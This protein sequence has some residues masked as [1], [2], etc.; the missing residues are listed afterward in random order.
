MVMMKLLNRIA[1]A[2][3]EVLMRFVAL[4]AFLLMSCGVYI[5]ND[6]YYT[7][8][9]A[10]ISYD[11]LQY[12]PSVDSAGEEQYGFTE[13]KQIN[14]DT[15]GWIELFDTHI[16]YPVVQ[17]H[18]N[19]EYLNKDIFGYNT[20]SGS[21]YLAAENSSGFDDW[22]N[23]VYGHH[24]DNGAM[25]GDIAKYLDPDF[26]TSHSDGILQTTDKNYRIRVIACIQTNAYEDIV[27]QIDG[28]EADKY[29]VLC[30][31]IREHSVNMAEL[32]ENTDG[33]QLI[34]FSTCTDAV[35]DGRVVLFA[36]VEP[37]D[38]AKDGSA[39]ER[40]SQAKDHEEDIVKRTI[41]KAR[42]HI[43]NTEKWAFLNLACVLCTFLTFLPVGSVRRK[44]GQFRYARCTIAEPDTD[45][46]VR[47]DL[48]GFL[49]KGRIGMIAELVF[50]LI[51]AA[52][53]LLPEDLGGRMT[54]SDPWTGVMI[55][56]AALALAMD[57]ICLRYR[58][59]KPEEP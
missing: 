5:V 2:A 17:G 43:L 50:W 53:F 30:D 54:I 11:L 8:R 38:D 1:A 37:W 55:A 34:G 32:P 18:D 44:L 49:R 48:Q 14:S 3:N 36:S 29:P 41:R 35:T 59:K 19:L 24:M 26:F 46:Q 22:Y 27:Y 42:G 12:R 51:S 21:I 33:V 10:F 28:T 15:V 9:T 57:F 31:Y 52:V 40:M 39:A 45:P 58:G 20:L 7:N 6:I 13:L 16:N 56:I 25:F 4:T 47:R 23:I